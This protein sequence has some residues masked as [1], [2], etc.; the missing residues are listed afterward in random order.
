M[1]SQIVRYFEECVAEKLPKKT[2]Q[3]S[4]SIG[5]AIRSRLFIFLNCL[6]PNPSFDSQGKE[7]LTTPT[8]LLLPERAS[9]IL[10][11]SFLK[12]LANE[13]GIVEAVIEELAMKE[14]SLLVKASKQ[15]G[16]GKVLDVGKLEDAHAIGT[17]EPCSLI[18][19]EGDSAKALA[20]AGLEVVGRRHYGVL[21]LRGKILNVRDV[22]A[23]QIRA[24]KEVMSIVRA[25]GLDFGETYEHGT[26]GLRYSRVILMTDQDSDGSHIKGLVINLF[27][28]YW[29]HLLY[30]NNFL[31]YIAT[32]LVKVRKAGDRKQGS[33]QSFYSLQEYDAWRL[34]MEKE[35]AGS[36]DSFRVKYYKGLGTSTSAEAKEY[37]SNFSKTFKSFLSKSK[38]ETSNAIDLA[39]SKLRVMD[40]REWLQKVFSSSV[41]IDPALKEVSYNDFVDKEL[42][43][44][45]SADNIRSIP[46]CI[47]GL[48]PSQRKVLY[49]CFKRK[50]EQEMKVVQL[51]G[52]VAEQTA[53]HHGEASLHATI[54]G[55]AQVSLNHIY[56]F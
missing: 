23:A 24:S 30:N 56:S 44:F 54:I 36:A 9:P 16:K 6:V 14:R 55:M 47:D 1:Q 43:Q 19:T 21:P 8:S 45:S 42:I 20:V 37:F 15:G 4:L 53:Y 10:S 39:F 3:S 13:T 17:S 32:P 27:E 52:Y 31:H 51:A 5:N 26:E 29:P 28:R 12:T 46:S 50:L 11:P 7:C 40:R 33:S 41:F 22:T 25:V 49:A 34:Q 48:K 2:K 18:L 35:A 38:E